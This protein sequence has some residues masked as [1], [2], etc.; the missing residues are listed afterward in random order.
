M[1]TPATK[2][3]ATSKTPADVPSILSALRRLGSAKVREQQAKQF[4]IIA[5]DAY[6]IPMTKIHALAR[7]ITGRPPRR[8]AT[9]TGRAATPESRRIHALAEDLWDTGVYEAR[10]LA[11]YIADPALVTPAQMDRWCKGPRGFEN[12][13]DC[14][15]VCFV[16]FDRVSAALSFRKVAAWT[17]AKPEFVRRAGF[18]LLAGIALHNKTDATDAMFLRTLPFVEAAATDDR[19]FVR[20]GASWALR[21]MG[22]RNATLHAAVMTVATRL[23]SSENSSARW[24]GKDVLRQLSKRKPRGTRDA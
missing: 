22:L 23:A 18:A 24:L 14:D 20:K 4:G 7:Q 1:P 3:A 8:S 13:G 6:G 2:R 16:L 10:L 5:Q 21:S 15:T 19:N 17:K 11:A 9:P 12:W